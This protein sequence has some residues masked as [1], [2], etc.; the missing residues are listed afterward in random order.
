MVYPVMDRVIA[1]IRSGDAACIVIGAEF[2]EEDSK[3]TFGRALKS[4]VARAMRQA[5]LPAA[6]QARLRSESWT[7]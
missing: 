6:V 2:M 5:D 3:F 1:G 7:C 4:H